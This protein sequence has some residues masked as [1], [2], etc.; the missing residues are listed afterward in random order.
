MGAILRRLPR[1][2]FWPQ[3]PRRSPLEGMT[4]Q[5]LEGFPGLRPQGTAG[6]FVETGE[7]SLPELAAF[8]ETVLSGDPQAFAVSPAR[9]RGFYALEDAL[10]QSLPSDL[11]CVKGHVTGPVT[12]ACSLKTSQG[13]ETV[14]D[15]TFREALGA[16][17]AQKSLWQARRLARFGVPVVL[18]LD[19]P[20]M[21]VY[22]SAYSSLSRELVLALWQPTLEAI[23]RA[24]AISGIHCCGNTDWGLVFES[25]VDIVNFDAYRYLE[26]MLLYPE[27]LSRHLG[28][29][30]CLAW[31]VVPTTGA[32]YSESESSLRQRLDE[33]ISR[34]AGAGLDE[35]ILRRQCVI[36]PSCGMGTLEEDLAERILDLLS[37][38]AGA[39]EA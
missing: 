34:F 11:T 35:A 28:S 5:Y 39:F 7:A 3:L 1:F 18:F 31:G 24:G 32:A 27:E 29:G 9:A 15:D 19:E 22:G 30:G 2:P 10:V 17:V 12:L 16:L 20:V 8:Y 23:A 26:K 37:R 4:L 6:V 14:H 36:T 13:K 21:E 33:G 38:V 25:G